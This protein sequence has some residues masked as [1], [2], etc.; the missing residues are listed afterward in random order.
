MDDNLI[1]KK[2]S[3]ILGVKY[4]HHDLHFA[5]YGFGGKHSLLTAYQ[6]MSPYTF[7]ILEDGRICTTSTLLKDFIKDIKNKLEELEDK[8]F[9]QELET[10]IDNTPEAEQWIKDNNAVEVLKSLLSP[11][12]KELMNKKND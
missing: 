8:Q 10:V 12:Y 1:A 11:F 9:A 7:S 5:D 6:G 4:S 3:E 2:V